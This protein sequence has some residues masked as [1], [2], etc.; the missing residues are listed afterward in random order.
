MS[1]HTDFSPIITDRLLLRPHRLEDADTLSALSN[2]PDL[3]RHL[4]RV[5]YPNTPDQVRAYIG[6]ALERLAAGVE[7][8]LSVVLRDTGEV[9]GSFSLR[10]NGLQR[11][12]EFGYWLGRAYWGQGLASEAVSAAAGHAFTVLQATRVWATANVDN[13]ASQRVLAKAGLREY[14]RGM[15]KTPARSWE[16]AEAVF[17]ERH[18]PRAPLL[19][20]AVA[21]VDRDGRVLLAQRPPGKQMAGL[22][23]FPG[24]KVDPGETPEAALIRELKEELDVDTAESCLAPF[25]FASHTY[26]DFHL[27]MPLYVCRVWQ[28]NPRPLEGQTLAWAR[29][30]EMKN[31]PM[32][33]AD[34]PLVAML[35]DLL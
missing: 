7:A 17:M 16:E 8:P 27:L 13:H 35:R 9:I 30:N 12:A 32:P 20:A 5:P 14:K 29:P 25:T 15:I 18:A 2:D 23:E 21:L 31:Y 6:A 10:I 24:G 33:P 28:G 34:K 3:V 11:H 26:E 22:W 4:A 1:E 19:V